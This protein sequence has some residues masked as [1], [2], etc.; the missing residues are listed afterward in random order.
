MESTPRS[1]SATA[2]APPMPGPVDDEAVIA[3][4][5]PVLHDSAHMQR[6]RAVAAAIR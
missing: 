6:R 2:V 5:D 1:A 3:A 4:L